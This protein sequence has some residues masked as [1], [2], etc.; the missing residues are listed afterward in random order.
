MI[1]RH[2]TL[3]LHQATRWQH[4]GLQNPLPLRKAGD[5]STLSGSGMAML[6]MFDV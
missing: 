2:P 1:P 4:Q 6:A 5:V 3:L